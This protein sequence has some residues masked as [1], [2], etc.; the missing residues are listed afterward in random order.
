MLD[1]RLLILDYIT[2]RKSHIAEIKNEKEE[3]KG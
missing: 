2:N 1:F 3:L